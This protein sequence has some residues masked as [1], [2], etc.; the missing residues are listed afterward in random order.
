MRVEASEV[1][2]G[3]KKGLRELPSEGMCTR[4]AWRGASRVGASGL[5]PLVRWPAPAA[6]DESE[7]PTFAAGWAG[8][9]EPEESCQPSRQGGA[10]AALS[11]LIV[12]PWDTCGARGVEWSML[13]PRRGGLLGQVLGSSPGRW[14][15]PD[16]EA[17]P[18]WA[19]CVAV[20]GLRSRA[21][22]LEADLSPRG[23]VPWGWGCRG[24]AAAAATPSRLMP[25]P[26]LSSSCITCR[27]HQWTGLTVRKS[28]AADHGGDVLGSQAMCRAAA[29]MHKHRSQP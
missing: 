6:C 24:A 21:M 7:A 8:R 10:G 3:R 9:R 25:A 26:A 29:L 17:L 11:L 12:R 14:C 4:R 22:T 18:R 15:E 23:W 2:E 13:Q 19:L 20:R 5:A 1:R 16:Q 28:G 27:A